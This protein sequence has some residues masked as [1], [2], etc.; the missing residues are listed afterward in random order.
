MLSAIATGI[1]AL[2]TAIQGATGLAKTAS[3]KDP[4]EA[5]QDAAQFGLANATATAPQVLSGLNAD[6]SSFRQKFLASNG[7][8]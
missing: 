2:G 4:L 1:Q 3:G 5:V 7:E 8:G 6:L